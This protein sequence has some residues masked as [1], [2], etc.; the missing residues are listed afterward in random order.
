MNQLSSYYYFF[1]EGEGDS[2]SYYIVLKSV[3]C[4]ARLIN[5]IFFFLLSLHG[6]VCNIINKKK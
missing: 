2:Q 4:S 3:H 1:F 6:I 5:I